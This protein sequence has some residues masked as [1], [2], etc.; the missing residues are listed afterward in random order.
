M[1]G[2]NDRIVIIGISISKRQKMQRYPYILK[3]YG[4]TTIENKT[5]LIHTTNYEIVV[6]VVVVLL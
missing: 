4:S 2:I 5:N 1:T 6:V 3:R